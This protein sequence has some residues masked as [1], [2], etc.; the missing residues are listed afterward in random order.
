MATNAE[1]RLVQNNTY[2]SLLMLQSRNEKAGIKV[3]GLKS[4]IS[5]T[6]AGMTKE[7]IAWVDQQ[8]AALDD[9]D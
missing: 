5:Q 9:D 2:Y 6:K 3:L 8:V 4:L 1:L 7:D